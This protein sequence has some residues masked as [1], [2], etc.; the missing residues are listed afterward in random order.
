VHGE[1]RA[2]RAYLYVDDVA[3][4][5]DLILHKVCGS[6]LWWPCERYACYH[7]NSVWRHWAQLC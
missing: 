3:E 5:F 1:G 4:A 2:R 6:G 7:G